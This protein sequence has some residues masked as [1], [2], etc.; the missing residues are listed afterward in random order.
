MDNNNMKY[1]NIPY[2]LKEWT[3]WSGKQAS[4]Y[5]CDDKELLNGLTTTSISSKTIDGIQDLID[6]YVD[7][8]DELLAKTKQSEKAAAEFYATMGKYKGD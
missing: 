5:Y 2:Y 3:S 4:A 8:K 6:T 1:R 7:Q